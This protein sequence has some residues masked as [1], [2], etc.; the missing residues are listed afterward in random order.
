MCELIR[1]GFNQVRKEQ[2]PAAP[3]VGLFPNN[4]ATGGHL[5]NSGLRDFYHPHKKGSRSRHYYSFC[6]DLH[7]TSGATEKELYDHILEYQDFYYSKGLTTLEDENF[8]LNDQGQGWVH[9]S[10]E[11]RPFEEKIRIIKP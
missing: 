10:I 4:W 9:V 5:K 6:A 2:N 8:T 1:K 11:W 3:E 7:T